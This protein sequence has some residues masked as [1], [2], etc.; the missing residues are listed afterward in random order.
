MNLI[1]ENC[2]F[3]KFLQTMNTKYTINHLIYCFLSTKKNIT[4]KEKCYLPAITI[5]INKVPHKVVQK[6]NLV[7]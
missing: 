3:N 2:G 5:Q 4:R 6:L 7:K 1:N